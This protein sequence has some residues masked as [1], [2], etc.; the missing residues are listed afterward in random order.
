MTS[1]AALPSTTRTASPPARS[2]SA[3]PP[4]PFIARYFTTPLF[5]AS[6]LLSFLLVDTRNHSQTT[7]SRKPP[8]ARETEPWFWRARHR[9]L[10]R[11]E[12]GQALEM[13]RLVLGVVLLV[14]G[15]GLVG[16]WWVGRWVLGLVR[17][18]VGGL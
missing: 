3:E 11:L 16:A 13:R 8:S 2:T 9:K 1:S 6:F 7:S 4:E 15:V 18:V 17:G 14:L 10:A 12:I 5:F